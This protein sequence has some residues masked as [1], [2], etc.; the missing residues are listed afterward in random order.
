M[1]DYL[2]LGNFISL[3]LLIIP[4]TAWFCGVLQRCKDGHPI[5]AIIRL[6]TGWNIIWILDIVMTL[7]NGCEVKILRLLSF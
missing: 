7:L 6:L 5:A 1:G 3:I 2:G 4:V